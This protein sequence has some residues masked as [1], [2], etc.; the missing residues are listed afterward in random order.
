LKL[1]NL[2]K[3]TFEGKRKL[4]HCSFVIVTRNNE[5]EL[6]Q[7][8][9]HLG[10]HPL[11]K[12]EFG[13]VII[14]DFYSFDKTIEVVKQYQK[15]YPKKIKLLQKNPQKTFIEMIHPFASNQM[16]Q[17]INLIEINRHKHYLP[18]EH[19]RNWIEKMLKKAGLLSFDK[20]DYLK[21]VQRMENEREYIYHTIQKGIIEQLTHMEMK[22]KDSAD[23]NDASLEVV[24][25]VLDELHGILQHFDPSVFVG[26]T[27]FSNLSAY[28]ED[29]SK[30]SQITISL[31]ET[32][33]EKK[34]N[35]MTG[36]SIIRMV[37]QAFDVIEKHRNATEID[38][39]IRWGIGKVYLQLKDNSKKM[40][41]R[42]LSPK[43]LSFIEER[44]NMLNG[45]FRLNVM[46]DKGIRMLMV[47]PF[48]ECKERDESE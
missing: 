35:Q 28:I 10:L 22:L 39:K 26:N 27:L 12:S 8:L 47:I 23:E 36:I 7:L 45:N 29:F 33:K 21:V 25:R 37:Q 6:K 13:N 17:F 43:S 42:K 24:N 38:V 1:S 41:H 4:P 34:I 16:L 9:H 20:V 14:V 30:K 18:P 5:E 2:R 44:L 15:K 46:H 31:S 32:G 11:F 19:Y 40:F 3:K 48:E